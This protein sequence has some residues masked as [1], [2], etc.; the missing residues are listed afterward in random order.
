MTE[1]I[2]VVVKD[3]VY[4]GKALAKRENGKT[5]FVDE[6]IDGEELLVRVV[7][8]HKT[9]DEATLVRVLSPSEHRI[10]PRCSHYRTCSSYQIIDYDYQIRIKLR[11]L[12]NMMKGI[13]TQRIDSVLPN[14]KFDYRNKVT[15]HLDWENEVFGYRDWLGNVIEVDS[16]HLVM[17]ILN[18]V[19]RR[20]KDRLIKVGPQHRVVSDITLRANRSGEVLVLLHIDN[21]KEEI[22]EDWIELSCCDKAVVGI[23]R[24]KGKS[25]KGIWGQDYLEEV[26]NGK[27]YRFHSSAFFQVNYEMAEKALSLLKKE[28]IEEDS[29]VVLD[30]FCGV[31]LL[32]L[33]LSDT[34]RWVYG[35]E[36]DSVCGKSLPI[37]ADYSGFGN[38]SYKIAS[39]SD[40]VWEVFED[41]TLKKKIDSVIVDPPRRGLSKS[42]RE[43]LRKNSKI[44][45]V[46]Y[47]SCDPMTLRR[48]LLYLKPVY[49]VKRMYF[50]DFFPQTYHI[51]TLTVLLRRK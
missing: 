35:V 43:F 20:I 38:F 24:I 42:V 12:A 51:E 4:P 46:F 11:Q 47:L 27:T 32:G 33:S 34:V 40:V 50:L 26:L 48:D 45:K 49:K 31:G 41:N 3:V 21:P 2:K 25:V 10:D 13:Y 22:S 17:P 39:S 23:V 6:G 1:D 28:V 18:R 16:C 19:W 36:S 15:F 8:E 14:N 37:N 5:I 44:K 30:L 9:Y 29:R 7:R